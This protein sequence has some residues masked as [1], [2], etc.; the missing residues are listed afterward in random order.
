M[1]RPPTPEPHFNL[2]ISTSEGLRGFEATRE[3]STLYRHFGRL[4][5]FNHAYFEIGDGQ[6]TRIWTH[7]ESYP[8][9][10]KFMLHHKFP[11][12]DNLREV[13]SHDAE[14]YDK[15]I[16]RQTSDLEN[17]PEDWQ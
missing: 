14:A 5:L 3:N 1:E 8:Q 15:M 7:D 11:L 2:N 6:C 9:V 12:H 13:N 17:L 10:E 4:A 16:E